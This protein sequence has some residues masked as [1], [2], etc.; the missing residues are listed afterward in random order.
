MRSADTKTMAARVLTFVAAA[1]LPYVLHPAALAVVLFITPLASLCMRAA[2]WK[3]HGAMVT[4]VIVVCAKLAG[5]PVQLC[6]LAGMWCVAAILTEI[7]PVFASHRKCVLGWTVCTV[8]ISCAAMVMLREHYNGL[9]TAGIAEDITAWVDGLKDANRILLILEQAGFSRLEGEL[10]QVP[11][12]EIFG[13]VILNPQVRVELLNSL[14]TTL[15]YLLNEQLLEW[16]AG[17]LVV[18]TLLIAVVP[19]GIRRKRGEETELEPVHKLHMNRQQAMGACLLMLFGL[20]RL[21][22]S[23]VAV[24]QASGM[25]VVTFSVLYSAQGLCLI[26]WWL[27]KGVYQRSSWIVPVLLV[28]LMLPMIGTILMLIGVFDQFADPRKLREKDIKDIEGGT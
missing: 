22:T 6:E 11:A 17:F 5:Q 1:V 23:S 20:V 24:Y 9:V 15:R 3:L 26:V 28:L 27:R 14:R 25:A 21:F 8:G 12:V 2:G 19:E 16:A 7:L 4:A 13:N 10:A 18:Q